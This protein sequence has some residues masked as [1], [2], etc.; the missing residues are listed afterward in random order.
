MVVVIGLGEARFWGLREEVDECDGGNGD[1]CERKTVQ[2]SLYVIFHISKGERQDNVCVVSTSL[3]Y[4]S[5]VLTITTV[6]QFCI[7]MWIK[8]MAQK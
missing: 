3:C 1:R 8:A 7:W 4:I 6:E 2:K 5:T